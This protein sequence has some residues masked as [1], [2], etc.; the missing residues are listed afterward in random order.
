MYLSFFVLFPFFLRSFFAAPK[1]C[2]NQMKNLEIVAIKP[3]WKNVGAGKL[4]DS[5]DQVDTTSI[6]QVCVEN[7]TSI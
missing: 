1:N 2:R 4:A 5:Q 3:R 6:L 7:T